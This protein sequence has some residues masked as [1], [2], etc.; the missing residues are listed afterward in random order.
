MMVPTTGLWSALPA[1]CLRYQSTATYRRS[2]N[3]SN[4]GRC[5]AIGV[6]ALLLFVRVAIGV[7]RGSLADADRMLML[8][9][10]Q[11]RLHVAWWATRLGERDGKAVSDAL[12]TLFGMNPAD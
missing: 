9:A 1:I 11:G 3:H 8:I 10:G 12:A 2:N 6:A 7:Q 5:A 4:G